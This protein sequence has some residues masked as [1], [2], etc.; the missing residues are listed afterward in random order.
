MAYQNS[1][2]LN[3]LLLLLVVVVVDAADSEGWSINPKKTVIIRN[4]IAQHP[5][6]LDLTLHCKSKNDDLGFHTLV[7][8]ETYSFRF[9]PSLVPR[10]AEVLYFCSF[11]WKGSP[12][13]H[14]LDVYNQAKDH[15]KICSWK[16]SK[17]GGCNDFKG[18]EVC[19]EW[20]R[21]RP[22]DANSTSMK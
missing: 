20:N 22:M 4:D 8:G 6:P 11:S 18:Y 10:I 3:F 1:I 7:F 17:N 16:I 21:I 19:E 12:Y 5:T 15:C 13:L 14:Y 9:R 2:T